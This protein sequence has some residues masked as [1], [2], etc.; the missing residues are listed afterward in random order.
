M[1]PDTPLCL[2]TVDI[3]TLTDEVI[4]DMLLEQ[5][6]NVRGAL[7]L[8]PYSSVRRILLAASKFNRSNITYGD[9]MNTAAT[10]R[11]SCLTEFGP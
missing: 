11:L 10:H 4:L 7:L 5:P 6:F 2:S 8:V 3:A 9:F 1:I